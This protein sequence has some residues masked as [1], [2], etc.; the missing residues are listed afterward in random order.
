MKLLYLNLLVFS[1]FLSFSQNETYIEIKVTDTL[2][3]DI[4]RIIYKVSDQM[5]HENINFFSGETEYNENVSEFSEN[6]FENFLKNKKIKFRKETVSNYK[7][8]GNVF[9]TYFFDLHNEEALIEL[10]NT[11]SE[12]KW[13]NGEIDH[14]DFLFTDEIQSEFYEK[15]CK[16]ARKEASLIA[17][18]TGKEVG[19]LLQIKEKTTL[20]GEYEDFYKNIFGKQKSFIPFFN[21]GDQLKKTYKKDLIFRFELK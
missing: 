20:M 5:S 13:I 10:V 1:V 15:L 7:I 3:L 4:E 8:P 9:N 19:D 17:E 12:I 14:V 16:K 6:E 21:F 18:S 11:L 2:E